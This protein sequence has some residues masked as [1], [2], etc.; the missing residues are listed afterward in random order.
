MA[1]I[2]FTLEEIK[3]ILLSN[4]RIP[5]NIA[6][7]R[8]EGQTVSFK[9]DMNIPLIPPIPVA[10]KYVGYQ[11][12]IIT[13]EIVRDSMWG[14]FA[15][16]IASRVISKFQNEM[17]IYT[18]LDYPIITVDVNRLLTNNNIKGVKVE[19]VVVEGNSFTI[20]TCSA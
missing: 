14:K 7:F 1:K 13:L 10:L 20:T 17:P 11:N 18:K 4:N 2:I 15:D 9:I 8:T 16:N 3:E 19:D 6:D 5:H 12:N